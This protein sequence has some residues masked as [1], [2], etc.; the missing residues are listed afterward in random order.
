MKSIM[1]SELARKFITYGGFSAATTVFGVMSL[2]VLTSF[3]QPEEYGVL[4]VFLAVLSFI[5]PI[6]T[7]SNQQN[8]QIKRTQLN[9]NLYMKFWNN[10]CTFSL[11][12]SL[13]LFC[14]LLIGV[15][16]FKQ[17]LILLLVPFLSVSRSVRL[18]KQAELVILGKDFTFGLSTLLISVIGFFT[19][20]IIFH[21]YLANAE[22]RIISL[23]I[24]E[25]LVLLFV[26]KVRF[27][28]FFERIEFKAIWRFGWPLILATFPAWL[29]NESSRFF[30]LR[31]E[32]LATVG[33]FTL[34][35]Q[36]AAIY[37]QFNTVL[38][39]TFVKR[40]F[41]DIEN[42][43]KAPFILKVTL[44]QIICAVMFSFSVYYLGALVLPEPYLAAL[45]TSTILILGVLFQSFGLL[46]SYYLS[47]YNKNSLRLYSLSIAAV[48]AVILNI[49]LIPLFGVTGAA[50]SFVSAMFL[51]AL[52]ISILVYISLKKKTNIGKR[53]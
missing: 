39:N 36:I 35:F 10:I 19:S 52:L 21:F 8:L 23:I 44:I 34:S 15:Y 43:F 1:K 53:V 48:V 46:P 4:G 22:I 12:V 32:S 38:G 18:L 25:L 50:I 42:T 40:V 3:L 20:L 2:P 7:L 17:P 30:L 5:L 14:L 51:Y 45:S 31:S 28:I 27:S 37:L 16:Y 6:N 47:Y 13:L 11:T 41:D 24:A 26:V 49:T 33:I 29:I 9:P